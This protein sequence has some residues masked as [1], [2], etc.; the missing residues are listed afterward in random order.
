MLLK[1]KTLHSPVR[2]R[3]KINTLL[4][5]NEKSLSLGEILL[6]R[7]VHLLGRAVGQSQNL[8][9]LPEKFFRD[10]EAVYGGTALFKLGFLASAHTQD[11]FNHFI[12]PLAAGLDV[13]RSATT[14]TELRCDNDTLRQGRDLARFNSNV[15]QPSLSRKLFNPGRHHGYLVYGLGGPRILVSHPFQGSRGETYDIYNNSVDVVTSLMNRG[16]FG[17]FLFLDNLTGLNAEVNGAPAWVLWFSM[18]AAHADLVV[19]VKEYE[20]DFGKSQRLEIAFTPDRVQ[21]KIV[22]IPHSELTWATLPEEDPEAYLYIG[23]DRA[24]TREEWYAEEAKHAM[25][26]VEGYAQLEFP[27]D[28]IICISEVPEMTQY[29]LDYPAYQYEPERR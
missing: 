6:L 18:I 28:R 26:F 2:L 14:E 12:A 5:G 29:P 24:L 13:M 16:Y 3:I 1:D 8:A 21:K 10:V 19:F 4:R 15:L 7:S 17:T 27:K 11:D 25:P 20:G 22:A 23:T 9:A